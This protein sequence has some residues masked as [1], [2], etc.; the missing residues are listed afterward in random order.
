MRTATK[1]T[2]VLALGVVSTL[3][4]PV[5]AEAVAPYPYKN[6]TQ[7]HSKYP[8]G[9]GKKGAHDRTSG[10]PVTSFTKNTKAYNKAMSYNSRLDADK[11][12]IACEKR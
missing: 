1:L 11:D 4:L 8:H 5:T 9:V 12:G 6:C 3:A 2:A 10:T 7:L